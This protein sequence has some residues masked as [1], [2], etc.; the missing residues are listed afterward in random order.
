MKCPALLFAVMAACMPAVAMAQDATQP[1]YPPGFDCATLPPG[2]EREGCQQT[3]LNPTINGGQ[4]GDRS[5][6]G[7]GSETPGSVSPPTFPDEPGNE[8][9]DSG[10]GSGGGAGGVGN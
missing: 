10:P 1:K 3:E 4:N 8:N 5:V 9:R 7:A 2:N 6:A